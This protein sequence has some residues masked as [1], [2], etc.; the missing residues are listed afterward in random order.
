MTK[1]KREIYQ[2]LTYGTDIWLVSMDSQKFHLALLRSLL[3]LFIYAIQVNSLQVNP[4]RGLVGELRRDSAASWP[5]LLTA[6][7][8]RSTDGPALYAR[9]VVLLDRKSGVCPL[10]HMLLQ[11]GRLY[12][13][14]FG[15]RFGRSLLA[16]G[17]IVC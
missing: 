9:S 3:T 15:L 16:I 10:S 1:L 6:L 14:L 13:L 4:R 5:N 7:R 8:D 2:C 12:I 17:E 11:V